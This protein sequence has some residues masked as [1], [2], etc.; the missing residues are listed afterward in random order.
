MRAF[1]Y[2]NHYQTSSMGCGVYAIT[3][4]IVTVT[5]KFPTQLEVACL[6]NL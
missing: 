3:V 5:N 4:I 1:E 2:F 6:Q